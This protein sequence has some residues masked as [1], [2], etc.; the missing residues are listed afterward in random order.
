MD[1]LKTLAKQN[2]AKFF[3]KEIDD[4]EVASFAMIPSSLNRNDIY[5]GFFEY[6]LLHQQLIK[7]A[8]QE[9]IE[10]AKEE[11]YCR[12]LG[13]ININTWFN[14]RFKVGFNG[15]DKDYLWE[16]TNPTQYVDTIKELGF[17]ISQS[18][19]T[20]AT[21]DIEKMLVKA[22]SAKKRILTDGYTIRPIDMNNLQKELVSLYKI[23]SAGFKDNYLYSPITQ[24]QFILL[25]TAGKDHFDFSYT[26]FACDKNGDDVGFFFVLEQDEYIV[27]KSTTV[28]PQHRGK[29]ISNAILH[30]SF[31]RAIE[32]GKKGYISALMIDGAQSN[33]YSKHGSF[34]WSHQYALFEYKLK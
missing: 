4:R 8:M 15:N 32:E 18:Y 24:E 9:A 3:S 34:L 10:W 21:G 2:G 13:P 1:N 6:E 22:E 16:P 19:S 14:Y 25:Y 17:T 20:I 33:S 31:K 27:M 26:S 7:E 29:G 5:F 28:L 12:I 11:G 23:S 30:P